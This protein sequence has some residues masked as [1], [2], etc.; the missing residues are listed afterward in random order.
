MKSFLLF[1]LI[2]ALSYGQELEGAWGLK[3]GI[4]VDS[5]ITKIKETKG[6]TSQIKKTDSTTTLIFMNAKWGFE[7]SAV[8][9]LEFYKGKFYSSIAIFIP[10]RGDQLIK[11][12]NVLKNTITEKY[13]APQ[14]DVEE[15]KENFNKEDPDNKK[16]YAILKGYALIGCSWNFD[17][18]NSQNA[19]T[20]TL[21]V[22]K[23]SG[24]ILWYQDGKMSKIVDGQVSQKAQSDF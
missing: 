11:V 13:F 8:T 22:N 9:R 18:L 10:D 15:Y 19:S 4:S 24:I 14:K 12:Y 5:A 7:T 17:S 3:W 20:I 6:Y 16:G 21:N 23:D 1:L 2:P